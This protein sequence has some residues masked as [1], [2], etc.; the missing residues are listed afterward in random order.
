MNMTN[1]EVLSATKH[2]IGTRYTA[3]VKTYITELTGRSRVTGPGE[4]TTKEYDL[5][6]V[7]VVTDDAGM[8]T[9]IQFG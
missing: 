4:I 5:T 7:A 8:I 3:A 9:A 1:E 2:L 6:R